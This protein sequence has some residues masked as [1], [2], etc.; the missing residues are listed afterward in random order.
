VYVQTRKGKFVKYSKM[1]GYDNCG[2]EDHQF[3]AGLGYIV[4]PVSKTKISTF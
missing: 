1:H 2:R 4:D 3:E